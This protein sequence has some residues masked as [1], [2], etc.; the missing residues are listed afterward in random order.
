[1]YLFQGLFVKLDR[2]QDELF[3]TINADFKITFKTEWVEKLLPLPYDQYGEYI[4]S[5]IYPALT[6][7]EKI[8]WN[9]TT[10][11]NLELQTALQSFSS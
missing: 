6:D 1:M 4:R 3:L 10:I 2:I 7:K 5:N 9:S 8:I 11:S